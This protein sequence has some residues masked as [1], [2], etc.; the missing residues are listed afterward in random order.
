MFDFQDSLIFPT[1]AVPKAGPM[2]TS[3]EE[4]S[5]EGEGQ[6]LS[7]VYIPPERKSRGGPD[8]ILGFGGNAW[9]AQDVAEYLHEVLPSHAHRVGHENNHRLSVRGEHMIDGWVKCADQHR[10]NRVPHEHREA[11]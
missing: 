8:L 6:R 4:L 11:A 3:A 2:P 5:L 9:N 1:H 7:G 10:R